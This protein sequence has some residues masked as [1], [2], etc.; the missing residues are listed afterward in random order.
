LSD[1]IEPKLPDVEKDAT[2]LNIGSNSPPN[3]AASAMPNQNNTDNANNFLAQIKSRFDALNIRQK[4]GLSAAVAFLLI[5]VIGLSSAGESKNDYKVLFSNLNDRDGSAIVASLQQM[6]VPYKFTEGGGALMVPERV[7]H[8]TRLKL[9]G[10]GLPK[11]GFVGFELLENQKLGTSQFVEQVN[12]QRGLEGELAKSISSVAQVK[13]ARV[14]LAVPKQS[15]FVREQEKATASVVLTM[16]PGRFMD[17]QQV[18]AMAHLVSSSVPKMSPQDVTIVDQ[19]GNMLAPNPQ[20]NAGLDSSQLKYVAELES[21]LAKR[22]AT[23]L[24]P[25]AGREN[26]RAQ[27]TIDMNF[28]ERTRTEETFGKNSAPNQSS[29]RSQQN[30]ESSGQQNASGAVPGA[31][32]N[33]PPAQ[34]LAPLSGPLAGDND[35]RQL[36]SPG[37]STTS[38]GSNRRESTVNYEVDKAIEYL[39]ANKGQLR[40]VSAAVVVNYK[41]G[42]L[43][44]GQ[45]TPPVPYTA[46]EIQQINGLV[47]D[48]VGYIERRG[49]TVSVANIPFSVEPVEPVPFYKE[50]GVVD[51]IKELT[52]FGLLAAALVMVYFTI[53]RTL[54]APKKAAE[55]IQQKIRIGDEFDEKVKAEMAALDPQLREQ[56]MLEIQRERE[57]RM[58]AQ[59]EERMREEDDR[60]FAEE[61]KLR[62]EEYIRQEYD[63]LIAYTTNFVKNDPQ[64]VA[65]LFKNWV[66]LREQEKK[67]ADDLGGELSGGSV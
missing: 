66:S 5:V 27:V 52:K 46:E 8:E 36:T 43:K 54:I 34:P 47:R 29:V 56:R 32:T 38:N 42:I 60:K 51:L 20:R 25:V 41:P 2:F 23:I 10:Q 18:I 24:E 9:A 31:L 44:D 19:D 62:K 50:A 57:R 4:L 15:A 16:Y 7:V 14:H 28:D 48:A 49:D 61:E 40:R 33:Q 65:L 3:G 30:I 6:N 21:A 53:V 17:P 45:P 35:A 37:N 63:D 39:K 12:Y 55:P 58:L 67:P 11:S 64:V 59:E 22:V 13:S 26:V 1:R